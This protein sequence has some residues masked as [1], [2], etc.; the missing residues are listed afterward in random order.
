VIPEGYRFAN[1]ERSE[2][3]FSAAVDQHYFSTMKMTLT[4]GRSFTSGDD[5]DTPRVAIVNEAFT[6]RYWPGQNPIGGRFRIDATGTPWM[7]IV[8]LRRRSGA[9]RWVHA[10]GEL[11]PRPP[12][13][14]RRSAGRSAR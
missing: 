3:M 9:P 11:R 2:V 10:D 7:E 8:G 4:R 5:M 6:T 12:C 1:G 13:R 14:A